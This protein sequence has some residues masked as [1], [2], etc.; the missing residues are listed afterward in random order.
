[1][2]FI[3]EATAADIYLCDKC[4]KAW[5]GLAERW[6]CEECGL[7]LCQKC[8]G[9]PKGF[10]LTGPPPEITECFRG[11]PLQFLT[12]MTPTGKFICDMC[13]KIGDANYGRCGCSL[14]GVNLCPV[15]KPHEESKNAHAAGQSRL[16]VCDKG[17]ILVFSSEPS[18]ARG[19]ACDKCDGFIA[20]DE[21]RWSCRQCDFDA[22]VKCRPEPK[23]RKDLVCHKR[24]ML[25]FSM[26]PPANTVF[27]RCDRCHKAFN[28]TQGRYCC[29][30]CG[31][32]LCSQCQPRGAEVE[33][34]GCQPKTTPAKESYFSKEYDDVH[35]HAGKPR[36]DDVHEHADK[37]KRDEGGCCS[38]C[39]I[40]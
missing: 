40:V 21:W 37:P 3:P 34:Y 16:T 14:C 12:S 11:H 31:F 26:L 32:D 13:G 4:G 25:Q 27:S 29:P 2:K 28:T 39:M 20:D 8:Y 10:K 30:V 36:R 7:D 6:H 23:G 17:H 15:C 33:I 18:G 35:E 1:M 9:P 38:G 24:H 19:Y 22:C 5:P